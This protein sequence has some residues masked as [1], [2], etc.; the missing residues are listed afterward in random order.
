MDERSEYE[1]SATSEIIQADFKEFLDIELLE[2]VLGLFAALEASQ[3]LARHCEQRFG[4]L[5]NVLDAST[6]ALQR[7]GLSSQMILT[8]KLIRAISE[9]LAFR[10]GESRTFDLFQIHSN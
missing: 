8:V 5:K 4:S 2:L 9:R 6:K 1:M 3:E 7:A 10:R